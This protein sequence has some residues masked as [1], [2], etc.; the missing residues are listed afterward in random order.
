MSRQ[1]GTRLE[2]LAGTVTG[3]RARAVEEPLIKQSFDFLI[4][5]F[6]MTS[7]EIL[8]HQVEPRG[9]QV[10]RG[11]KRV[12]DRWRSAHADTVLRQPTLEL[13]EEVQQER[14]VDRAFLVRYHLS[15]EYRETLAVGRQVH[16]WNPGAGERTGVS[17]HTRGVPAV[18][19]SPVAVYSTTM[20][21]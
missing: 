18:N 16:G 9:E 11:A 8:A 17:D 3:V 21:R 14:R 12:G 13:V 5:R 1:S 2:S 4:A 10:E 6:R 7:P 19:D 15:R 20:I